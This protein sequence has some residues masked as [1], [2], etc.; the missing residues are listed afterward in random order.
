MVTVIYLDGYAWLRKFTRIVTHGYLA[1]NNLTG[2]LASLNRSWQS[3]NIIEK[4][5]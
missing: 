3:N 4:N 2:K 5:N 1:K